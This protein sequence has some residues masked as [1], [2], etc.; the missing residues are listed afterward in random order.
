M[1]RP[2]IVD[3]DVLVDFLRGNSL[4]VSFINSNVRRVI[5]S[6]VVVAELYAGAKGTA[7]HATLDALMS[8][9]RV[10][11]VTGQIG[12][13]AGLYK[14]DYGKS[15]GTGIID[16]IVAATADAESADVATLNVKHFP[17]LSG[18]APAY[19]K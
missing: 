19:R 11:P 12:R 13:A 2:L 5:L 16:C 6:P 15:H 18:L 9:F 3:T 7:E 14:R 10:S 4:A 1:P 17:M 8:L